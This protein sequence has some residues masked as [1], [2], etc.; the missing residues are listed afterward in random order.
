MQQ[1][2]AT[3]PKNRP[4]FVSIVAVLEVLAAATPTAAKRESP[5]M[6]V[7]T[8]VKAD[9]DLQMLPVT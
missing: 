2:W 6:S 3:D 7:L 4:I 9:G 5:V 1:C 8:L